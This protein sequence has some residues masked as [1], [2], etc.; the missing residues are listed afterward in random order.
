MDKATSRFWQRVN[1]TETCWL[2][3]A[4]RTARGYGMVQIRGD[5]QYVHRFVYEMMVG[6]IPDGMVI[7]HL[8]HVRHCVNPGHLRVAT[9]GVNAQNRSGAQVNSAS[10]IRGVF[11]HE[12]RWRVQ[13][14][15]NGR[16]HS[17][18]LFDDLADAEVA[19]V[20]LRNRLGIA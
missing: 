17:G 10:G 19:A 4:G 2:W 14:K 13:A 12:G 5:R 20:A 1:K 15:A 7:D 8:C 11:P 16:V 6:P 3:T 18:G 9:A